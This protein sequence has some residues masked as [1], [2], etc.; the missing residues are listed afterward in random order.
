M[1]SLTET[2]PTDTHEQPQTHTNA[3]LHTDIQLAIHK[4]RLVHSLVYAHTDT[5]THA[6]RDKCT[7]RGTQ[8]QAYPGIN[9]YRHAHT[10]TQLF[11]EAQMCTQTCTHVHR[12]TN[13]EARAHTLDTH[14]GTQTHMH[15][16]SHTDAHRHTPAVPTAQ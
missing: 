12:H 1:H 8:T 16:D 6:C 13:T 2:P 10:E 15:T 9:M 5:G 14:R 7:H 3:Y 11:T 4:H